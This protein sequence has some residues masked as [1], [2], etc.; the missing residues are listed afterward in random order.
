MGWKKK[1]NKNDVEELRVRRR[2]RLL[3]T[4]LRVDVCCCCWLTFPTFPTDK[5]GIAKTTIG[6][7]ASGQFFSAAQSH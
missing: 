7:S 4:L 5:S 1:E 2:A 6:G 3:Y